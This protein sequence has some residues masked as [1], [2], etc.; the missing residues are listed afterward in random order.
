MAFIL[1]GPHALSL[2]FNW[3]VTVYLPCDSDPFRNFMG[4]SMVHAPPFHLVSWKLGQ[5]FSNNPADKQS[6]YTIR[7]RKWSF[8]TDSDSLTQSLN[9]IGGM[10]A[11]IMKAALMLY[12]WGFEVYCTWVWPACFC[13]AVSPHCWH[14]PCS[15]LEKLILM[16]S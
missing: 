11:L 9:T 7:A 13:S 1:P 2:N 14:S 15:V 12:P 4:S 8:L 3:K 10:A 6:N 5:L 16:L